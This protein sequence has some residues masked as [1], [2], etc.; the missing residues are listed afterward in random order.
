MAIKAKD[1]SLVIYNWSDKP[2]I[3]ILLTYTHLF[4]SFNKVYETNLKIF[5]YN[6]LHQNY[7]IM[8]KNRL[9]EQ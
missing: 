9:L 7:F 4:K 8:K 1:T 5:L 2:L 6:F 3:E